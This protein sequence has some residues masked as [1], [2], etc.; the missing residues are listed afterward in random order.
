MS[1]LLD[2][3]GA[4]APAPQE[5]TQSEVL[6]QTMNSLI[7]E[8]KAQQGEL[9]K[10]Q[11]DQHLQQEMARAPP[12][13]RRQIRGYGQHFRARLSEP[14]VANAIEEQKKQ[15][16]DTVFRYNEAKKK[17]QESLTVQELED[18]LQPHIAA[19]RAH[20]QA[21]A[22][23]DIQEDYNRID[24]IIKE[25]KRQKREFSGESS[26]AGHSNGRYFRF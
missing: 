12:E 19:F 8:C 21:N 11:N 22:P 16:E 14:T 4:D 10:M 7:K 23:K 3:F 1:W 18:L 5:L 15:L 17:W 20:T 2:I 24:K 13:L 25:K 26:L 9:R 6:K